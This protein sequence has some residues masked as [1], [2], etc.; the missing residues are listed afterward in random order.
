V[1]DTHVHL[2]E[3]ALADGLAARWECARAAGVTGALAVG[4]SPATWSRTVSVA[5]AL[6][7]V[8]VALGIHPQLVAEHDDAT[9]DEALRVLPER[10]REAGAAAVGEIGFDGDF[11]DRERQIRVL[12]AQLDVARQLRLPISLHV[13]GAGAYATA[14]AVLR[15]GGT[16]P[17]GGA[18]HGCSCSAELVRDFLRLGLDISF[19]GAV[20]RSN[21]RR[22]LVAA[23][24]VPLE[25][26]LVETDAPWQPAGPDAR[27]RRIGEPA[28]LP[29]IVAALARARGEPF[30]QVAEATTRN[31]VRTFP[32]LARA[33]ATHGDDASTVRKAL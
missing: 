23:R 1:I 21:A 13:F 2:D 14:L 20:T 29:Q 31:A 18:L 26:L 6:P 24:A 7:G 25:R 11:P 10:L 5:R 30:E 8:G 32:A 9:L 15:E 27:H 19:A 33:V 16:L 22:P 12:R 28:D 3:P 17:A 4:V